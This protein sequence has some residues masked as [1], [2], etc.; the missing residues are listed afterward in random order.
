MKIRMKI[1]KQY[2]SMAEHKNRAEKIVIETLDRSAVKLSE[3]F[4]GFNASDIRSILLE[5]EFSMKCPRKLK[6]GSFCGVILCPHHGNTA[7]VPS[8]IKKS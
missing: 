3:L 8:S 1:Q 6:S 4:K 7:P 2:D 5:V